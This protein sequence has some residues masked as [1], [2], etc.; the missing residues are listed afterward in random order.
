MAH[1]SKCSKHGGS[2]GSSVQDLGETP[3]FTCMKTN[4]RGGGYIEGIIQSVV[5]LVHLLVGVTKFVVQ[6]TSSDFDRLH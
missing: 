1:H 3:I 5:Q 2:S 4:L 6:T